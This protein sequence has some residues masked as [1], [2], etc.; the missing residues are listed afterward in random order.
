MKIY[1]MKVISLFLFLI[2]GSLLLA[3]ESPRISLLNRVIPIGE[4]VSVVVFFKHNEQYSG[5]LELRLTTL[6]G[7][8]EAL[9][10]HGENRLLLKEHRR[11]LFSGLTASSQINNI[12]LSLYHEE[13]RIDTVLLTVVNPDLIRFDQAI[14]A[15]EKYMQAQEDREWKIS[16]HLPSAYLQEDKNRF[17]VTYP[18]VFSMYRGD[19]VT[20]EARTSYT[21]EVDAETGEI[22]QVMRGG[23]RLGVRKRLE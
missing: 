14:A 7:K 10:A 5:P 11:I 23:K 13:E 19:M 15:T 22:L 9:F 16:Y 17:V 8:G 18:H 20:T 12:T 2:T 1:P 6:A 4:D 3:D 21:F